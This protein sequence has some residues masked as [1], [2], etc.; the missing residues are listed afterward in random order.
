MINELFRKMA[1]AQIFSALSRT[2]CM[3]VDSIIIGR[4]L[5]VDS[6]SAYGL[7]LPL[8][9]LLIALGTMIC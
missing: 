3:L 7:A 6:M 2:V 1:V 8:L 5:G 9:T 4:L